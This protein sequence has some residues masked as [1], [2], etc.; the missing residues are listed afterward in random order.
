MPD[1]TLLTAVPLCEI[2]VSQS[3]RAD[4]SISVLWRYEPCSV[5]LLSLTFSFCSREGDH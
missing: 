2:C 3:F 5:K 1:P 4:S